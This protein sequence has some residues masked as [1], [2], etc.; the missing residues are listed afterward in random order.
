MHA[1]HWIIIIVGIVSSSIL[2]PILSTEAESHSKKIP[3]IH[4][5]IYDPLCEGEQIFSVDYSFFCETHTQWSNSLGTSS[6]IDDYGS[7]YDRHLISLFLNISLLELKQTTIL[8]EIFVNNAEINLR[9]DFDS[10]NKEEVDTKFA[11]LNSYCVDSSWNKNTAMLDLP[12]IKESKQIEWEGVNFSEYKKISELA[13]VTIDITEH[14]SES[15]ENK[16]FIF[17]ELIQFY[18]KQFRETSFTNEQRTC[19]YNEIRSPYNM[20]ECVSEN[21]IAVY[22]ID[23]PAEGLRPHITVNYTIQASLL[24][25]ILSSTV[26]IVPALFT[27]GLSILLNKKASKHQNHIQTQISK[28]SDNIEEIRKIE[29]NQQKI[30]EENKNREQ[31]WKLEWGSIIIEH[32]EVI[33]NYHEVLRDWL[34]EFT[35]NRT[36][37]QKKNIIFS[38]KRLGGI[39]DYQIQNL[40]EALS[41]IST[42][43]TDPKLSYHLINQSKQ[44]SGLFYHVGAD[45]VWEKDGIND[46]LKSIE[47]MIELLSKGIQRVKN[48]IPKTT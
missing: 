9:T 39:C 45:Y 35:E 22:G 42:L 1:L 15:L 28:Q 26:S 21:R 32:L 10:S 6:N 24:G 12:C 11:I 40:K 14:I 31:N 41:K 23:H 18:P 13:S 25:K 17:T 8:Q 46:L 5:T 30:T 2:Y 48:E 38:A 3:I 44:F 19:L 37:E 36:E 27:V 4:A 47:H 7:N 43:F 33:K 34:L 16:V 29:K 20:I